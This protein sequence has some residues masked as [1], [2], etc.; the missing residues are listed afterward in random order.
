MQLPV[1]V[2]QVCPEAQQYPVPPAVQQTSLAVQNALKLKPAS[3][4]VV[5]AGPHIA[6]EEAPG[7]KLP[8]HVASAA[9]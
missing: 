6:S 3:Q 4:N 7:P 2:P 8:P 1:V 5:P 9:H